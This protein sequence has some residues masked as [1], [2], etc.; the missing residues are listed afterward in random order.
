MKLL[1]YELNLSR[2]AA[3]PTKVKTK[4]GLEV[5]DSGTR[6]LG[7]IISEEYNSKLQGLK[8]IEI[9]DEM[10]KSDASVKAAI[11]ATTL[12]IRAA[13]WYVEPASDEAQDQEIAE[14]VEKALMEWQAIEWEDLLRQALLSLPF[15]FMVFE[16]VYA[17]RTEGGKTYIVW[18]KLAP[19]MPRSIQKWAIVNDAPGVTQLKSDGT[20]VEIPMEKLVVIV[21]EKEGDNWEGISILRAA[22]KHWFM[23][24]TFYKIDAIAFERQGL[25]IPYVK[26]PEQYTETDRAKAEDIL[27]NVRANSQAYIIEPQGYEIGFKDM[28]AKTT[29]DPSSSIA[30][31]NREILKSVLA[32]FLDLGSGAEGATGS[33]AVSQD[34]SELFLQAVSAV[35]DTIANA[36]NKQAIRELVD[37]N[38]DNVETYPELTYTKLAKEDVASISAAYQTLSTA[39]A[40][41]P[42]D[43]DEQ[44]FRKMLG[45][46]DRDPDEDEGRTPPGAADPENPED[47]T[48]SKKPKAGDKEEMSEL[49]SWLKKNSDRRSFAEDGTFKPYRR[50]TFAEQKV[51]FEALQRQMDKLEGDFDART[52]ELLHS[53][54][55]EYMR[56][57]TK[58]ALAGD[59]RGIKEATLKVQGDYARII[60]QG[61]TSAFAYGKTNAAKELGV[62]APANPADILRQIDIQ[63]DTIADKQIAEIV[64]DSKNAYVQAL[65]KGTS[66]PIAL[67][68]ADAAAQAAIDALTSDA[69]A[70][71]MSGYINHGR[72]TVFTKNG[73]DIH[74]LQRSEILDTHTCNFCL[75][76]DG[77]VLD[78]TDSFT[79][80]TIFHSSCRGIW[81]AIKADEAELPAVG[82]VPKAI[83][84]RF[85][86]A[87]N[88]LIQPKRPV[89]RKAAPAAAEA[90]RR[91]DKQ[92]DASA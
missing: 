33:R 12:P 74:A 34:H 87:V 80:N 70:I 41:V 25:G 46:P 43:N 35:A 89:V 9:Y 36:F 21:H 48:N 65:N 23:K 44:H 92:S 39:G 50:L 61:V 63:S 29:R 32:Q 57:M 27:K 77:R 85:G 68:A 1:G 17:T 71:L 47:T 14:F 75:S 40:I 86:D 4:K 76:V 24:N 56:A 51:D 28:M 6:I 52:K 2:T 3:E 72:N 64:G 78:K 22:Y 8:G 20:P 54:R 31:H 66:I 7:G 16:K 67:A 88:D 37:L 5:G 60:K 84:D 81:V 13:T 83:R 82:G 79:T 91:I 38:F 49:V 18:D 53:A 19:R 26:L 42:T 62:E 15:G 90:K 11:S 73:D 55:T 58:A 69:S 59:T 45:L 30:H 10:R